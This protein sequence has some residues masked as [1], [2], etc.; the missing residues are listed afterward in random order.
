VSGVRWKCE[1]IDADED[2]V[3]VAEG[4]T[5]SEAADG[6]IAIA[7]E[8]D[9]GACMRSWRFTKIYPLP[10]VWVPPVKHDLSDEW[11]SLAESILGAEEPV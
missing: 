10:K 2:V 11:Y 8:L 9:D 6:A 4:D 1:I 7:K 5:V 3:V